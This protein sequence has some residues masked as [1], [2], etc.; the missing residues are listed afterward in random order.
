M[1]NAT[2]PTTW[3]L[4]TLRNITSA[5]LESHMRQLTFPHF[6]YEILLTSVGHRSLLRNIVTLNI[7]H[8]RYELNITNS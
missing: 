2:L 8:N 3:P 1:L 6:D 4:A 7:M 5:H